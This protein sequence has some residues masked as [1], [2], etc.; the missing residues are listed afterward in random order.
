MSSILHDHDEQQD[1]ICLYSL[2]RQDAKEIAQ[3]DDAALPP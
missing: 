2:R 3:S 1:S